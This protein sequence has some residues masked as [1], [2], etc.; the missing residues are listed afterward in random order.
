[1]S[2]I[3][4][5]AALHREVAPLVADQ[6]WQQNA[7]HS[8]KNVAVWTTGSAVIALA[9]MG[10]RRVAIAVQAALATGSISEIVSAGWAGACVPGAQVGSVAR[11]STIVDVRT[12]ERFLCQGGDGSVLA[13]VA[14]FAGMDEK[15]RLHNA[16]GAS[17]VEMEAATVARLAQAHGLPFRAVKAISDAADLELPEIER[18]HTADGQFREVAFGAFVALRPWLWQPVVKMGRGS[19]LAAGNLCREIDL[20]IQ[21][22][23]PTS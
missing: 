18:F 10:E 23:D 11:P 3:A 9:G 19:K 6:R 1:M 13:T 8:S 4:I 17:T 5:I 21:R 15:L 7:K 12:G 16:Y 2:R 22:H 20:L 14:S